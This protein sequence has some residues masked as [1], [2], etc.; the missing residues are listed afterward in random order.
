M[1][2]TFQFEIVTPERVF[3]SA[4]I[5]SLIAPQMEGYFG[6]LANHA[7]L[8]ARSAGGKLVVRSENL[9]E[10]HFQVGPGI[11]EVLENRALFLTREAHETF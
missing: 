11:V 10:Q 4:R 2:N 8:I 9:S 1:P 5:S 3:Y 7:P 6:V